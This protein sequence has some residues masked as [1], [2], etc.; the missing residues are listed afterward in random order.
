MPDEPTTPLGPPADEP[1]GA[2]H[3]DAGQI[4][5]T[6][7]DTYDAFKRRNE[8]IETTRDIRRGTLVVGVSPKW[9]A[10]FSTAAPFVQSALPER[11]TLERS[12]KASVG[13]VLP[14]IARAAT[15]DTRDDDTHAEWAEFYLNELRRR[16]FP[17]T[18]CFG[19][20]VEDG[21]YA[22]VVIPDAATIDGQPLYA[23][24]ITA[25]R[26]KA[27]KPSER[28][29]YTPYGVNRNGAEPRRY[30]RLA[31]AWSDGT[32]K[33]GRNPEYD[34]DASGRRRDDAYYSRAKGPD[35]PTFKRDEDKSASAFDTAQRRYRAAHLPVTALVLPALDVAPLL[36]RSKDGESWAL[37]AMVTRQL[38]VREEAIAAGYRWAGMGDRLLIPQGYDANR[39]TGQR[40][41]MYLYQVYMEEYDDDGR[42][43]PLILSTV[44]G[45]NAQTREADASGS[46]VDV[47]D[48]YDEW[49]IDVP[50]WDYCGGMGLSDDDPAFAYE[51]WLWPFVN[52]ILKIEGI[53][54]VTDMALWEN[55]NTGYL[56]EPN[57]QFSDDVI[58]DATGNLR[59]TPIP[60]PGEVVQSTGPVHPF[61]EQRVNPDFRYREQ[62]LRESLSSQTLAEQ[63]GGE[64]QSGHQLVVQHTLS[65][66]AK[67]DI[68]AGVLRACKLFARVSAR[69]LD[70][71]AED[72]ITWPI[73]TGEERPIGSKT[74]SKG[75]LIEWS[76]DWCDGAYEFEVSYPSEANPVEIS[77]AEQAWVNGSGTW[78]D[79]Q[80]AKGKSDAESER[81]KVA[82]DD[83]WKRDYGKALL[84]VRVAE[85]RQDKQAKQIARLRADKALAATG[86]PG[87]EQGVPMGLLGGQQGPGQA[88]PPQQ[89]QQPGAPGVGAPS[90]Q[91]LVGS[92]VGS[93]S[94]AGPAANDARAVS[95]IPGGGSAGTVNGAMPGGA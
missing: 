41:M 21:E 24:T 85:Y 35:R 11:R 71:L 55:A 9:T 82:E 93:N 7:C 69:I 13:A 53:E 34:R 84:D 30:V 51:P 95:Q 32:P 91:Q 44:L 22:F 18:Q 90:A 57:P 88:P 5:R 48:L 4:L 38:L 52:R 68:R 37:K 49:G 66:V 92:I 47:L 17:A 42:C 64:G 72:G 65:V 19:K 6:F 29:Q 60:D 33:E 50:C 76:R 62:A 1:L 31:G 94:G 28:K 79:L 46:T 83:F 74:V 15:G 39:N 87:M 16:R 86:L 73:E 78:E 56:Q 61:A 8:R 70:A 3:L 26:Y 63:A 45:V 40:G 12:V 43:H 77:L 75:S 89:P 23:D 20:G 36:V 80:T 25:A 81:L 27:L 10:R 59:A 2:S 67:D 14:E 58:L 54:T